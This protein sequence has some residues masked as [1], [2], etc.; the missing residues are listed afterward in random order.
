MHLRKFT[1]V[2]LPEEK[3]R[4]K[5]LRL[6]YLAV[7]A[8]VSMLLAGAGICTWTILDYR[9]MKAKVRLLEEYQ[10]ASAQHEQEL[11]FM[12][13]RIGRMKMEADEL[14]A[15]YEDIDAML[16]RVAGSSPSVLLGVGGSES[17][18]EPSLRFDYP[19]RR[20]LICLMH[21]SLEDLDQEMNEIRL[22]AFEVGRFLKHGTQEDA[23]EPK[24]IAELLPEQDRE[25]IRKQLKAVAIE[26]GLEP[27]LA[28]GIAKVES[29]YDPARVSPRGAVGVLQVMPQLAWHKFNVPREWLFNPQVNIRVGLTWMKTLLNRFDHNLDLALA[30]YNA[31]TRRVV[32][33]GYDIPAI[34]ETRDYV[35]KVKE[36]MK[37][38]G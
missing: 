22:T 17:Y 24:C 29:Q 14:K 38:E 11:V 8:F 35:K 37:T 4:L 34:K 26:L 23:G 15:H 3:G 7:Y 30:A 16:K 18:R 9:S 21:D 28:F 20:S 27:S 2:L 25:H 5:K 12:A 31:G 19:S 36:A 32:K 13:E 10:Q 33:A 6:S 1:L